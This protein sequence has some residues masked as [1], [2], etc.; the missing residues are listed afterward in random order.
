MKKFALFTLAL[1]LTG[2]VM[3]QT[4]T[5]PLNDDVGIGTLTPENGVK[6]EVN[7]LGT[8]G[9]SG[10]AR[11]YLGT[12]NTSTAFIQSRNLSIN[13]KL[14]FYGSSYNFDIGNVGIGIT[15]PTEKLSV[16]G[17]IRAKEIKVEITGWPDYVF[18]S[19]YKNLSLLNVE[20]FIKANGHLPGIPSAES[21]E[22]EG[23][24]LGEMNKK[25]LQ[26]IEEL[27]LHLIQQEKEIATLKKKTEKL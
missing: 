3:G 17:K 5:F 27:T 16:N 6:L 1:F 23:I 14:V 25:L 10:S 9:T 19:D 12:L 22:K 20:Q 24:D 21:I 18:K 11:I 4:N 15:D 26:K 8:I 13:Q 7:G 2:A